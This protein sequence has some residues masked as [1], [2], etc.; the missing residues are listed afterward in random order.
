MATMGVSPSINLPVISEEEKKDVL[1]YDCTLKRIAQYIREGKAKKICLLTGAGISVSAGIPDFRTPGTGLYD[2]LQKYDL[3]KPEAIFDIQFFH[4]DPTPFYDLARDLLPSNYYP[5]LMHHFI[6]LLQ[7]KGLLLRCYTQNIDTLER[8]AGVKSEY[9]IEAHGSFGSCFCV[10][11][12]AEYDQE[13]FRAK[14][15]DMTDDIRNEKG[16][17]IPWCKCKAM[18]VGNGDVEGDEKA[19]SSLKQCHGNVKP[20][21]VFFGEQL[22]KKYFDMREADMMNA[23]LLIVAGTSLKVAPFCNT[24]HYCNPHTPRVLLNKELVGMPRWPQKEQ[25][26][27]F[28]RS[29]NYRDVAFE[30]SCDEVIWILTDLIGWRSELEEMMK[31]DNPQWKPPTIRS[32]DEIEN[33]VNF[34]YRND[35]YDDDDDDDDDDD[36]DKDTQWWR[37]MKYF[38]DEGEGTENNT[39]KMEHTLDRMDPDEMNKFLQYDQMSRGKSGAIIENDTDY[40]CINEANSIYDSEREDEN[41]D[42]NGDDANNYYEFD[43]KVEDT[44]FNDKDEFEDDQT[45]IMTSK[46]EPP[47]SYSEELSLDALNEPPK[48]KLN[49]SED[50]LK[51]M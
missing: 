15:V 13:Y 9:L 14:V 21:I 2:N 37:N 36:E 8:Q 23:D 10:I 17:K 50:I 38:S 3:P 16:E 34:N 12:G 31:R 1:Q 7:N 39:P 35:S 11:C 5:T 26:F 49:T 25:G 41:H 6:R 32:K 44:I 42:D 45:E 4:E 22:P 30:G 18:I 19:I 20:N 40:T 51:H 27:L 28:N 47:R 33:L 46:K 24:I 29:K 43:E 48:K